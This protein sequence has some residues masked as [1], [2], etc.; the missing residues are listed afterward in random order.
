VVRSKIDFWRDYESIERSAAT[1]PGRMEI[2][3][4]KLKKQSHR[5]SIF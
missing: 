4:L 5:S 2:D 3:E 1:R